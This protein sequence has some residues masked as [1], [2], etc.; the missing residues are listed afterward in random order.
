[1][2]AS[3]RYAPLPCSGR[4]LPPSGGNAQ[5]GCGLVV[6]EIKGHRYLYFWSY[7]PR[8]WGAYRRWSYVGRVGRAR[9]R[10]RASELLLAYHLKIRK[11]I[12]RRIERLIAVGLR[13]S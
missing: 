3:Y 10:A 12:D 13:G 2:L 11:E 1:M 7:E 4:E 8:S 6:R 5:L 9:T